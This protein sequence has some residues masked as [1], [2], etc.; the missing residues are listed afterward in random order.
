MMGNVLDWFH[1]IR[2]GLVADVHIQY[3]GF[4]SW[5]LVVHVPGGMH[6]GF[7]IQGFCIW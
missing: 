3:S 5:S 4:C 7:V 6:S 2:A 1:G